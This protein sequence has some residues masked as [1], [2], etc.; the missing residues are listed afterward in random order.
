M[1]EQS[2][3]G[4]T[5]GAGA[6]E[7]PPREPTPYER[8]ALREIDAFKNPPPTVMSWLMSA[9][10]VPFA[11]AADKVLD[12]KVGDLVGRGVQ[13]LVGLLDDGASWSVRTRAIFEEYRQA[14]YAVQKLDDIAGLPL[15]R[16]DRVV[17]YVAAKYKMLAL[18]EGA[19]TGTAGLA[20]LVADVPLVVGLAL[21]AVNEYAT[22]YGF[23]VAQPVE[24]AVVLDVLA[25]GSSPTMASRRL[26]LAEL[27]RVGA[28]YATQAA[29]GEL[30]KMGG[31]EAVKKVAQVIGVR[32]S[33]AKLAQ[34]VPLFGA[35]VGGGV[36]AWYM[37]TVTQTAYLLYRE[38][39]LMRTY[40]PEVGIP[41]RLDTPKAEVSI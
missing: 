16:A 9:L 23:D 19:A 24:R 4:A 15:E 20:G 41:V 17:A 40:G 11:K 30:E 14:G 35:A 33:R 27:G 3:N 12:T 10:D 38:R 1:N 8:A 21:R 32:L 13:G 36:N 22:Y 5:G 31:I 26:A 25:A 37:A 34:V 7:R 29:W 2:G 39:F 28:M 6:G 18:A